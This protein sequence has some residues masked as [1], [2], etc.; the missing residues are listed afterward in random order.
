V[1]LRCAQRLEPSPR[2]QCG[3]ACLVRFEPSGDVLTVERSVRAL[4]CCAEYNPV[5]GQVRTLPVFVDF[6]D[7]SR[8]ATELWPGAPGRVTGLVALDA[9]SITYRQEVSLPQAPALL[10]SSSVMCVLPVEC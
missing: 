2:G 10:A 6:N 8:T 1:P 4:T 3:C 7:G 9:D 5:L